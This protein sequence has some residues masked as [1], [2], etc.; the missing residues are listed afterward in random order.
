MARMIDGD[1]PNKEFGVKVN[2]KPPRLNLDLLEQDI[3]YLQRD[4]QNM[5]DAEQFEECN[6]IAGE[7]SRLMSIRDRAIE[8]GDTYVPYNV[9][10]P[11]PSGTPLGT[12]LLLFV[13][14]VLTI[15]LF[16]GYLYVILGR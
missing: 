11:R 1:V 13:I 16:V 3:A 5:K 2:P 14:S 8:R 12:R 10:N 7:I 6:Y 15:L 9:I 4:W